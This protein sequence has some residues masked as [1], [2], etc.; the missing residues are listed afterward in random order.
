MVAPTL[1]PADLAVDR[2]LAEISASFRLLLDLT[3]VN[4]P[5]ARRRFFESPRAEPDFEYRP[6]DDDPAVLRAELDAVDAES[7]DDPTLAHLVHAKR[8]ELELHVD[9]LAARG[10][11]ELR[12]LSIELYGTVSPA[13]LEQ[14]ES[15]L[16]ALDSAAPSSDGDLDAEQL[17]RLAEEELD[18]YRAGAPDLS[19]H[20][21]VRDDVAGVMVVGGDLLISPDARVPRSRAAALLHHEIGT[22]VL[23]YVNGCHQRLHL[24]AGGLAG[25]DETQEALA[26]LAEWAT[27]GLTPARL[28]QVAS[29]VVAVHRMVEGATFRAVH[30][31]LVSAGFAAP[32]AFG[33]TMRVFRAGGL[34]KDLVYLR[35]LIELLGHLRAGH[36]LDVLWLG[37]MPL[38]AVPL[39]ED[40]LRRGV[41]SEPLLRPRYLDDPA[42]ARRLGNISQVQTVIELLED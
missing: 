17:A 7:V 8:R 5:D 13:L 39:V 10:T 20:V 16:R 25:Y 11:R 31:E 4:V 30:E 15:I 22:H 32:G 1:S 12:A 6:L 37:K 38:A 24:L 3:P 26:L 29:R 9:M 41:L 19:V 35:G 34:T 14:A 36:E 40:L 18:H 28:R 33:T 42:V 21:E 2:Q 23:T 27:G